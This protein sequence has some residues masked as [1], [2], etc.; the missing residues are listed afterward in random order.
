MIRNNASFWHFLMTATLIDFQL[1]VV[2]NAKSTVS[3]ELFLNSFVFVID[4]F[5]YTGKVGCWVLLLF[6]L[7]KVAGVPE[8]EYSLV[9]V[10]RQ[11]PPHLCPPLSRNRY[12]L[13]ILIKKCKYLSDGFWII[14]QEVF[15]EV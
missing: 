15:S 7:Y 4:I 2:Y 6:C 10:S 3:S 1:F 12:N 13:G 11:L 8:F 9:A 5:I 14:C